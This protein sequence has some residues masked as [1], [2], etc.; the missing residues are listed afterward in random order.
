M[1]IWFVQRDV[2]TSIIAAF[3]NDQD[4]TLVE[5]RDDTID[6]DIIAFLAAQ[7]AAVIPP[8]APQ[9]SAPIFQGS[10][11]VGAGAF[12]VIRAGD[13]GS[14]AFLEREMLVGWNV[15]TN[16]A[17]S[18]QI[19]GHQTQLLFDATFAGVATYILPSSNNVA[20]FFRCKIKASGGPIRLTLAATGDFLNGAVNS[21]VI[22]PNNCVADIYLQRNSTAVGWHVHYAGR[23]IARLTAAVNYVASTVI[24]AIADLTLPIAQNRYY[25]FKAGLYFSPV[26]ATGGSKS[27]VF[28]SSTPQ[29]ISYYG[30][31][32]NMTAAPPTHVAGVLSFANNTNF[33]GVGG[34][35]HYSEVEGKLFSGAGAAT[36]TIAMRAAQ[37]VANGTTTLADG[38][39]EVEE[40]KP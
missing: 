11:G 27:N 20:D 39:L 22:I 14:A 2:D 6:A 21:Q 28:C 18:V 29:A 25:R 3:Q 7:A 30:L 33:N 10:E 23:Q 34:A 8:V 26:D 36:Q 38:F 31:I 40:I 24:T 1:T 32:K 9:A 4:G 13:L 5:T 16:S 15:Q 19:L 37:S 12:G 17:S 35:L